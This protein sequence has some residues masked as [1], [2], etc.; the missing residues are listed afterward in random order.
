L[1]YSYLLIIRPATLEDVPVL[2]ETVR[3]GFESY[4][5][6]APPGWEPPPAV[7]ERAR[8]ADQLP[9]PDAWCRM[10]EDDGAPAGHVAILADRD[11]AVERAPG[12][13]L[14]YLWMLFVRQPWWGTG[15]ATRLIALAVADAGARG[16]TA[17]R[18]RTPARQ[19]RARAFYEREGWTTDGAETLEPLIGLE[20]VEYRRAL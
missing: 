13:G 16:Y 15:L 14:A 3:E 17:M 10:A 19:A 2:A 18:L 7:V 5:A 6:F 11:R 8:I 1:R 20:L 12:E 4:R 9:L